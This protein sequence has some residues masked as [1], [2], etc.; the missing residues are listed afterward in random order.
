MKKP[1]QKKKEILLGQPIGTASHKLRKSILFSLVKETGKDICFQCGKQIKT[2]DELSI[3]HKVPWL[4]A[5]NPKEMFFN[6]DNI[7]FSHL[8]CNVGAAKRKGVKKSCFNGEGN[9]QSKLTWKE[10]K[11]IRK[12]LVNGYTLVSLSKEYDTCERNIAKI[13]DNK[14][15]VR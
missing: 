6:L 12:K 9:P 15:W 2:I 8:S 14:S 11:E 1:S 4:D 7:A 3:E 5:K 13:R 10:V